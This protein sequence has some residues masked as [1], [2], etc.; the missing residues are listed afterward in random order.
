MKN[1]TH[2]QFISLLRGKHGA[3]PVGIRATTDAKL[4]K[5]GNPHIGVT[6]DIR[7]VGFVGADYERAVQRE[8]VARQQQG[9]A[10]A[11]K[12]SARQWGA[13]VEGLECK[14]AAHNGRFYLRTQTTPGMRRR[15]PARVLGYK[16]AQGHALTLSD[17]APW[18]PA[19]SVSAKQSAVG[20]D[21][22]MQVDVREYAFDSIKVVRVGGRTY[23]LIADNQQ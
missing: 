11:F 15:Q 12:A 7:A 9:D 23:K 4:R 3:L 20:M 6:K 21:A 18:L 5:T 1:L 16:D 13:W 10:D 22:P 19:K 2:S 14:V 8:G 17:I